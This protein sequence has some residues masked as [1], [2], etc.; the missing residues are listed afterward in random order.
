MLTKARLPA[1]QAAGSDADVAIAVL[2]CP[3][4]LQAWHSL[5]LGKRDKG[6]CLTHLPRAVPSMVSVTAGTASTILCQ[7]ATLLP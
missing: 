2:S 4:G 3:W 5:K 7:A 1:L 6:E